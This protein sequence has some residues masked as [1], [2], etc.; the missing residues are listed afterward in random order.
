MVQFSHPYRAN[1]KTI[2]LTIWTFVGN[3]K[4]EKERYNQLD[5]QLQRRREIR[6]TNLVNN[7]KK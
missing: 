2:A 6:K 3:G 1:G 5:T 4:G 7:A